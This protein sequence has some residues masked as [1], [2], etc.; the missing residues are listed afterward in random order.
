M[1][2]PWY[3]FT[4]FQLDVINAWERG[5]AAALARLSDYRKCAVG[6]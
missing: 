1:F 2:L 5:D 3:R 6:V 4:P